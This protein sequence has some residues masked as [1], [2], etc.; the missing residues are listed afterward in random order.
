[1]QINLSIKDDCLRLT[2]IQLLN[3]VNESKIIE[4]ID[5]ADFIISDNVNYL[6]KSN[7]PNSQKILLG[8]D[9]LSNVKVFNFPF[10]IGSLLQYIVSKF[11]DGSKIIIGKYIL[12]INQ[13]TLKSDLKNISLTDKELDIL[14]FLSKNI[15]D[16]HTREDLLKEVWGY[17]KDITTHTVETHIYRLRQKIDDENILKLDER[18][19]KLV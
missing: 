13:K 10:R 18:G 3:R 4:N 12:S 8:V 1:M 17:S 14:I 7:L 19:Y 2:L 6:S 11:N 16:H 15:S 5:E 9:G